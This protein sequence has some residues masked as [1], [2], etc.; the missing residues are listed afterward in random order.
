MKCCNQEMSSFGRPPSAQLR[1]PH[2]YCG[3]CGSHYYIDR[4][5]TADEWFFYVNGVS[6]QEYHRQLQE[7]EQ[8]EIEH[9]HELI[10]HSDP[11]Q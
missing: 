6:Y 10:N 1:D 8:L 3:E 4:W 5:Y 9:A 2:Y 11:E 7:Q